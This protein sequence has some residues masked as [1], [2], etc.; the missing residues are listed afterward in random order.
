MPLLP[1]VKP[2]QPEEQHDAADHEEGGRDGRQEVDGDVAAGPV[3][4]RHL[5]QL[6]PQLL[7]LDQ[8]QDSAQRQ[9]VAGGCHR[10]K[11]A[12]DDEGPLT[13]S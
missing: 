11:T 2:E 7:V 1:H 10:R 4:P 5:L 3:E 9:V 6:R 8:S 12:A 13:D